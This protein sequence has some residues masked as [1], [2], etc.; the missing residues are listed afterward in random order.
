M[1]CGYLPMYPLC[2]INAYGYIYLLYRFA[3]CMINTSKW[4]IGRKFIVFCGTNTLN[5][6]LC[7]TIAERSWLRYTDSI[8]VHFNFPFRYLVF[9]GIIIFNILF[10]CGYAWIRQLIRT[11]QNVEFQCNTNC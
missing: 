3:I 1:N 4:V 5:I 11:K 8:L 9:V 2:I 10:P 7:H 6:L